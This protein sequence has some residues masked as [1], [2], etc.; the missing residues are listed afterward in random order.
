MKARGCSPGGCAV[1]ARG[2]ALTAA[3]GLRAVTCHPRFGDSGSQARSSLA[4]VPGA[5]G[6]PHGLQ[7]LP[8]VGMDGRPTQAPLL[9]R[10]LRW[11]FPQ[12]WLPEPEKADAGAASRGL[13]S[14]VEAGSHC[15]TASGTGRVLG[16]QRWLLHG[17]HRPGLMHP[18]PGSHPLPPSALP[19]AARLLPWPWWVTW[20]R[21]PPASPSG[22]SLWDTCVSHS[23]LCPCPAHK[24]LS[25]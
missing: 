10:G 12:G 25:R 23:D 3:G 4:A 18:W 19:R 9:N 21:L 17:S 11:L 5:P 22:F 1:L 20:S 8:L 15:P 7:L 6:S 14:G 13:V 2:P 24:S 16:G